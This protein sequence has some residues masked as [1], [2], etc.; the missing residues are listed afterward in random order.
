MKRCNY[1]DQRLEWNSNGNPL[2]GF[3]L[4]AIASVVKNM[5]LHPPGMA[6]LSRLSAAIDRIKFPLPL[7]RSSINRPLIPDVPFLY[8]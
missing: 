4:H 3:L 6:P 5:L 1:P 7:S 8:S 2:A